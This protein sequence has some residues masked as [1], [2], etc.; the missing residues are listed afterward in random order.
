MKSFDN[1]AHL[2]TVEL[3]V[4][5][6]AHTLQLVLE[7]QFTQFYIHIVHTVEEARKNDF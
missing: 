4:Y 3:K 2:A 1:G 6:I 5:P 7:A